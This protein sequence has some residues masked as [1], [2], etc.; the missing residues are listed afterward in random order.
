MHTAPAAK[1]ESYGTAESARREDAPQATA[2]LKKSESAQDASSMAEA[3]SA[4]AGRAASPNLALFAAIRSADPAAMQRALAN[5]ADKNAKSNGTPAITLC[6]Q[7]GKLNLVQLL[8]AAGADVNAPDA[9]GTTP[10]AHARARGFDAI[11]NAL[12]GLGAN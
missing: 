8:A 4:P 1:T 2:R 5:G 9:Q 12:I 6:V 10:L 7:S 3:N 11:A